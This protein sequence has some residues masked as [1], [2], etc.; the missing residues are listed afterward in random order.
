MTPILVLRT[1]V[2]WSAGGAASSPSSPQVAAG[3][4]GAEAH[5]KEEASGSP[6]GDGTAETAGTVPVSEGATVF[7]GPVLLPSCPSPAGPKASLPEVAL[8]RPMKT[9][10]TMRRTRTM[11]MTMETLVVRLLVMRHAQVPLRQKGVLLHCFLSYSTSRLTI[12]VHCLVLQCLTC[13]V[14]YGCCGSEV[15]QFW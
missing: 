1:E 5:D 12:I 11:R 6:K 4:P 7:Q 3:A 8:V 13:S 10:T 2:P 14:C 15:V 9:T